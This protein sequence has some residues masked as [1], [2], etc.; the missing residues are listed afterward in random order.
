M[1]IVK[2]R[3]PPA[4]AHQSCLDLTCA[5][6]GGLTLQISLLHPSFSRNTSQGFQTYHKRGSESCTQWNLQ[7]V[8]L[9][10]APSGHQFIHLHSTFH[11]EITNSLYHSLQTWAAS[12]SESLSDPLS[13]SRDILVPPRSKGT[14]A[15]F[16]EDCSGAAGC[17]CL[18]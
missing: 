8:F 18:E 9:T 1:A 11:A 5:Q 12:G 6:R 3:V 16:R 13:G 14:C 4:H 15:R 2:M 7:G 10:S 17:A